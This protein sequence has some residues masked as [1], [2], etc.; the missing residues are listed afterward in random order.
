MQ[1]NK[2]WHVTFEL[3]LF[4]KVPSTADDT[5]RRSSPEIDLHRL[6]VDSSERGCFGDCT[7]WIW[8]FLT[9]IER[10]F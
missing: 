5:K 10:V 1:D 3:I 9:E 7:E 4:R 8:G 6:L 2:I